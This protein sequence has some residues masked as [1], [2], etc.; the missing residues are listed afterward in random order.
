V[1]PKNI[2]SRKY[3][4]RKNFGKNHDSNKILI[5]PQDSVPNFNS[6]PKQNLFLMHKKRHKCIVWE[7][8]VLKQRAKSEQLQTNGPC[9]LLSIS[10]LS[11]SLVG[12]GRGFDWNLDITTSVQIW[13]IRNIFNLI[14]YLTMIPCQPIEM[15]S[16]LLAKGWL[17]VV[18]GVKYPSTTGCQL[19]PMGTDTIDTLQRQTTG[20]SY[21]SYRTKDPP[22]QAEEEGS[23]IQNTNPKTNPPIP[24]LPRFGSDP[25]IQPSHSG[26]FTL[27][28]SMASTAALRT[29]ALITWRW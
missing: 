19:W 29:G 13:Y 15:I 3:I 10:V 25:G 24:L 14:A 6:F 20:E 22:L 2:T 7:V 12:Y 21:N 5:W 16:L 26:A 23:P 8:F 11:L 17:A 4:T 27:R 1:Y 18:V 28:I 9:H